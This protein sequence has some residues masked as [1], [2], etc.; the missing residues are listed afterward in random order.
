MYL[1]MDF[2]LWTGAVRAF[3]GFHDENINSDRAAR[4][5]GKRTGMARQIVLK[6]GS[7]NDGDKLGDTRVLSPTRRARVLRLVFG[8]RA[9]VPLSPEGRGGVQNVTEPEF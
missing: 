9:M 8:H 2:L 4:G 3:N 5:R 1:F 7:A 6:A